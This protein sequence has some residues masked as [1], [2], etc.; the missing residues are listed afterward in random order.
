MKTVIQPLA[1]VPAAAPAV[2]AKTDW[3]KR[4]VAL[5]MWRG[6]IL[7]SQWQTDSTGMPEP[8]VEAL[9]ARRL[10]ASF[11]TASLPVNV[12]LLPAGSAKTGKVL[13]TAGPVKMARERARA[14]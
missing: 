5:P 2:T 8:V 11:E 14:R 10:A 9:L 12:E 13:P 6:Q 1:Q 3:P 4:P 7:E